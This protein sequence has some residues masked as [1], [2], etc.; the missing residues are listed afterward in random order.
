MKSPQAQ[1]AAWSARCR[2]DVPNRGHVA[3]QEFDPF[4]RLVADVLRLGTSRWSVIE[5]EFIRVVERFDTEYS[6]GDRSTGWYQAKARYFNDTVVSLLSNLSKRAISTRKKKD[7]QLFKKLDVD[8]CYP[9]E[10][11]PKI[12][13]EVKALGTPP[14]PAN[15]NRAR[16]GSNDLHKR[17]REVAFTSMDLK[18]AYSGPQPITSFQH[19]IDS[20]SPGYFSFWAIRANDDADFARVRTML[21]SLRSYCNGVAAVIYSPTLPK[22]PTTY[23][24][25]K[26]GE[27]D[28]DR[29]I[30]EMAQRIS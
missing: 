14:H 26:L 28:I 3:K 30:R 13:G 5:D 12:A 7:S 20:T 9:D 19:W 1:L 16:S 25:R 10:G 2:A 21:S 29:C 6:S 18:V 17:L 22:A 8:I 15:G 24:V 23:T 27:L 4:E 11:P